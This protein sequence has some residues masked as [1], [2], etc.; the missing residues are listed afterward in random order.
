MAMHLPDGTLSLMTLHEGGEAW[1]CRGQ[2]ACAAYAI[3]ASFPAALGDHAGALP[4]QGVALD[5]DLVDG[6]D[7]V[8]VL[9]KITASPPYRGK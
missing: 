5:R 6:F 8:L 4:A 2:G 3:G 9:G 1:I 7:G